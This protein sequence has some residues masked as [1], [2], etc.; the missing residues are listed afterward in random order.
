M[1]QEYINAALKSAKYEILEGDGS[2]YGE[3]PP[4]RGVYAKAADFE[5]CRNELNSILE[6]WILIRLNRNL[7]IPIIDSINLNLPELADAT[8]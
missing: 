6:E 2:I 3:I 8:Y 5:E 7:D 1:F 4:C